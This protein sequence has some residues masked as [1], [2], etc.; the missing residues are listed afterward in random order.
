[1]ALCP[2]SENDLALLQ[3]L[4]SDPL[5]SGEHEWHGWQDTRWLRR[6]WEE[7]GLLGEDG[8]T[9]MVRKG[10]DTLGFVAWH[11]RSYGYH[12]SCWMVS[13]G[14]KPEA[15][16]RGYGTEAQRQLTRYLFSHTQ[17]NR[18]EAGTEITN[19]GEQRAL[20]KAGFT[21]EGVLRGALF[22]CGQWHD[23]VVYGVLRHEVDLDSDEA[24]GPPVGH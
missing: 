1:M 7:N 23:C 21:R 14:L 24:T 8:G 17:A 10:D 13:I 4:F 18:I 2:V 12:S 3:R 6:R 9:L 22:R 16:G 5:A 20:E 19:V 15:R 11:K